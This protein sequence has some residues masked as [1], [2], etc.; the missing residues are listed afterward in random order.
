[1]YKKNVPNVHNRYYL[2]E[3]RSNIDNLQC[4]NL[5]AINYVNNYQ[6]TVIFYMLILNC[7]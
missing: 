6:S 5:E 7:I 4:K 3:V 1:M 2:I